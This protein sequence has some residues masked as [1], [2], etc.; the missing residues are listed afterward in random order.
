MRK[1]LIEIT[2]TNDPLLSPFFH[3]AI[4]LELVAVRCNA[5]FL[6]LLEI[7]DNEMFICEADKAVTYPRPN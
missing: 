4:S 7:Q 1:R 6:I 3:I 2:K 5:I